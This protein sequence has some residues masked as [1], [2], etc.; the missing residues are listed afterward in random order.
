MKK[1]YLL[2]L[3]LFFITFMYGAIETVNQFTDYK[4]YIFDYD[5][6]TNLTVNL[7]IPLIGYVHSFIV[8]IEPIGII[9]NVT[10]GATLS[11]VQSRT[12]EICGRIVP[13]YDLVNVSVYK[14]HGTTPPVNC[15]LYKGQRESIMN[16]TWYGDKCDFNMSGLVWEEGINYTICFHDTNLGHYNNYYFNPVSGGL[17][18]NNIS[19]NWSHFGTWVDVVSLISYGSEADTLT[20]IYSE[21]YNTSPKNMYIEIGDTDT[22]K[23]YSYLGELK[24]GI[25]ASVNVSNINYIL[26]NGC[27]CQD[28]VITSSNCTMPITF[29]SNDSNGVSEITLTYL[30]YSYDVDNCSNALNYPSNATALNISF[31]DVNY[32]NPSNVNTTIIIDAVAN[33]SGTF[34]DVNN[35]QICIYSSWLNI[36][37]SVNIQYSIGDSYNYY[38]FDTYLNNLT[39]QITLYTQ[40]GTSST[41]FTITNKDTGD[42]LQNVMATMYKRVGGNWQVIES[43]ISDIT[44][45]VQ[46]NYIPNTEYRFYLAL[47][48]YNDYI[49]TLN[50]VLYSEYDVKMQRSVV[51]NDTVDY[52]RVGITY[53]PTLFYEGENNFTFLIQSPYAELTDYGYTLTY[54]GG[55][56]GNSGNDDVGEELHTYFFNISGATITDRL[57]IDYYYTTDLTGTLNHTFYHSIVVPEGNYT[58]MANR[59]KTYG[60]GLFER[61]LIAVCIIILVTGIATLIGRPIEGMGLGLVILGYLTYIGLIPI[62]STLL[63]F[64]LGILILSM[65]G[66]E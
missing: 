43:K 27:S 18:A 20:Y 59:D 37:A 28:C 17:P 56:S 63:T 15:S 35:Y 7:S 22:N 10:H 57:R 3:M 53:S 41:I 9:R 32:L 54:P 30:N 51:L 33:Y 50:P 21:P 24:Q 4:T 55:T 5:G 60:L 44:G 62:W 58:M 64:L 19:F 6:D 11:N 52:D 23:E 48:D 49:F 14:Q 36:S 46:F 45:R 16:T 47:A 42:Y 66:G 8:G 26:S 40:E 65:K 13:N 31:R 25:N 2:I 12:F 38:L 1:T 29:N 61:I 39:Q 34:Y